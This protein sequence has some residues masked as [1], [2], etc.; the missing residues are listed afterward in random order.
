MRIT[1]EE[2]SWKVTRQSAV[3]A[4]ARAQTG[5]YDVASQESG[6]IFT[7][8]KGERRFFAIDQGSLPTDVELPNLPFPELVDMHRKAKSL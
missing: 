7:S 2:R 4:G 3:S 6:L 1:I 8:D 5:E